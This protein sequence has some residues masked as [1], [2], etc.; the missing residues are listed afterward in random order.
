MLEE[1]TNLQERIKILES[2][3]HWQIVPLKNYS[4]P[5]AGQFVFVGKINYNVLYML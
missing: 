1:W 2:I 4:T 3:P 5:F